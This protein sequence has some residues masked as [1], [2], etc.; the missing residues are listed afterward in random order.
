MNDLLGLDASG[1]P[2]ELVAKLQG[3]TQQEAV[4]QALMRQAMQGQPLPTNQGQL[5]S[6]QGILAPIAQ[7]AQAYLGKRGMDQAATERG[8]I[9][10][11]RQKA[12]ADAL[13][14]YEQQR[15]GTPAIPEPPPELGGGPGAPAVPGD[16]RK[17]VMTA[18]LSQMPE[19]RAVA[20]RDFKVD[21]SDRMFN[22]QKD[23]KTEARQEEQAFRAEQA[24]LQRKQRIEELK[25]KSEDMRLSA[26]ERRAHQREMATLVAS[27]RQP[28]EPL[29]SIVGPEG[30]PVLVPRSQ[31]AGQTPAGNRPE[32]ALPTTLQNQLTDAAQQ[33]DATARFA[34][35][36]KPEFGGKTLSGGSGNV[37][38]RIFGDD[39][40]QSQWWQDY[41]L[42]QSQVRNKLFGSALTASEI[43]AW[44]KSAINPRMDSAQISANLQRQDKIVQEGLKRL[45]NGASAGGYNPAQIEAFTNRPIPGGS[46]SASAAPAAPAAD[47][48]TIGGKTYVKQN[49]QWF[50]K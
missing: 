4:A 3:M 46:P 50:E 39:T 9:A 38:G 21:E 25:I 49:G 29:V 22:L 41:E 44:N 11:Q 40:G 30:R 10:N 15:A 35:T 13:S 45:M 34:S 1:L 8:D 28:V 6:R 20:D 14:A 23:A 36:F 26:E 19:L 31:A 18:M 16:K 47:T 7:I 27:L 2:P 5:T 33:A 12:V 17:A 37:I 32:K 42:H 24:D 48:K 43:E